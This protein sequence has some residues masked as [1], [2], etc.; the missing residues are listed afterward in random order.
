MLKFYTKKRKEQLFA[1]V[2][3]LLLLLC[4]SLT[5][6]SVR[7]ANAQDKLTLWYNKPASVWTE[8]LPVG[9]GR[10]GA[11]IYGNPDKELLQLNESTFWSGGPVTRGINPNAANA[12]AETRKALSK[13][14]YDGATEAVKKMQGV[15]TQSYLP[16]ADLHLSQ[17]VGS[18]Y[19]TNY[20]RTLSV[21]KSIAT[22]TFQ[23][24]GVNYK[25][26]IIATFP[27]K[28]IVVH[29]TA[30]RPGKISFSA[31]LNSQVKYVVEA[32]SQNGLLLKAKAP[33]QVDPNYVDYNKEPVKYADSSNCKGMRAALRVKAVAKNGTV[34]AN[35]DGLTVKNADEVTLFICAATSFNGYDKCPD[36]DGRDEVAICNT[37]MNTV[38]QKS[39]Q[40]LY[41]DHLKDYTQLFNR[42]NIDLGKTTGTE[43]ELPTDQRLLA[44][45]NGAK[46]PE[47][48]TLFYQYGRY[49]LISSSRP[50]GPPANLQGIWN[51]KLRA[52]WSSNF[53]IN[54]NT[55]MN[56]WPAATTNLQELEYPLFAFIKELSVTG[57]ATA[58]DFYHMHGWVAHHNTDI[59]AIS[60]PVGDLGKGEPKWANWYMGAPWLCRHL[61]EHYL[62]T[63]DEAF[64]KQSYPIMK[65]A[66]EFLVDFLIEDKNGYLITSPSF[67]PENEFIDDHGKPGNTSI[68]TTMDMSIIR[69]HFRNCIE[70]SEALNTDV[71][72]RN[73]LKAKLA[74]LYPL[75]IG[76]KGNL[77]EWYKD[78]EDV[79]PH[80]RHV[81]QLFGLHPGREISPL[82]NPAYADAARKTLEL[83]GDAGTGWSLAWKI[84]FWARLLDGDHAYKLLRDLMRDLS[85]SKGGGLYPNLFDA[86][87]PFQI[88]GNFGAVSGMTEMLLQS[89]LGEL[90]L[91]PALPKA[92]ASGNVSGLK[93]RGAFTV[94]MNWQNGKLKTSSIYAEKGGMVHIR[95]LTPVKVKGVTA[96]YV[97]S[98]N[99]YL[100]SFVAKKNTTYQLY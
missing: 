63:K 21:A 26:E 39:W 85:V 19:Y 20:K 71:A 1:P 66:A 69:D 48:E 54:I 68:A 36:S 16:L 17:E 53:T 33:S 38:M 28:A 25:R 5:L 70:A 34:S 61:F 4:A 80:H 11:M 75:H 52:P 49:L 43:P 74:K 41:A 45:S 76:H 95:T 35:K 65:G 30:D 79:D 73:M 99:G 22:V 56:Y 27:G 59:W 60:N 42:V 32:A 91:L 58:E 6:S 29:L 82:T 64:L 8:A 2:A 96:K 84:N 83:R 100:I 89:H 47:L 18:S 13:E 51:N 93:A 37:E 14:D 67:S 40:Q 9:N 31:S 10:V 92:W 24:A 7:T 44:F 81:S 55:Q 50:G 23:A 78:W 97:A 12:L 77:Q 15:Y 72:F 86:H 94:S 3:P 46:D 57:K 62:F 88:D 90:Q 87:P 98:K